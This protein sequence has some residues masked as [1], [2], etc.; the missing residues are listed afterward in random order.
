MRNARWRTSSRSMTARTGACRRRWV[1]ARGFVKGYPVETDGKGLLLVGPVG[2]GK[3]HVAVG[4]LKELVQGTRRARPLLR[5]SGA[6]ERG[7]EQLQ[8]EGSGY[9]AGGA[10]A[11]LRGR[12]AGAGRAGRGQAERLGV[13]HGGAH[14]EQSLQRPANDNHHHELSQHGGTGGDS[15]PQDSERRA[16]SRKTPSAP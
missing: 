11:G 7:A 9:R 14:P 8:P 10:A 2:V 16:P 4:I 15:R 1:Q 5:L 3:T 13:G 12:G 6:A